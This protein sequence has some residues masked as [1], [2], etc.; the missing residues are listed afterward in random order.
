VSLGADGIAASALL[1]TNTAAGF[2]DIIGSIVIG[3]VSGIVGFIGV[4]WL[5]SKLKYDDSLDAFGVHGLN[6]IWGAI[7]TGIFANPSVNSAGK[8]SLYGNPGQ[9]IAQVEA[10]LAT[11]VY[12][13]IMTAI[14]YFITSILIGG[15]RVDEETEVV[16][17]DESVHGERS[18]E[19]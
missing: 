12:T 17:L 13:A 2:V 11:I 9:V 19:I 16:G 8:G 4:Y 6:G 10:V 7:A 14:L 3:L 15:A 18:F 5:K 1:I